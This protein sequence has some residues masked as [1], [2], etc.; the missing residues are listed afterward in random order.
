MGSDVVAAVGEFFRVEKFLKDLNTTSIA[1]IPKK[2]EACSLGDYRP[3]SCCNVVYKVISKIIANRLKPILKK[4]VSPNQAAFL[5][6]RSLGENVLLASELIRDYNKNT[7]L[8]SDMLK[9]DIRKAF[10]TVCWDFI[11][12][13]LQAQ[14]FP[15]M[16]TTW[17]RECIS[18]PRFSVAINGEL[19]GFFQ[20]KKGL[21]QGDSISP[22]LFIMVMEVLS[23]LLD[24][25]ELHNSFR[26]H[27]L[28]STP[29]LTHLLF[30]DDLLVFSDG[31]RSSTNGI[32]SVMATF[33]SW[34]GLDMNNA[35]SE[36]FFGGYPDIQASVMADLLGFRRG[37][38]PTRYLGLLLD[39]KK[40]N[41]ATLQPFLER[42]TSKLHSWTVK[43]LSFA[44]KVKLIYSVIYGM[45][46]FWSSVFVLPKRFY[47]KVDSLCASFLWKNSTS[48]S[49]GA[50]VSWTDICR[51]K[52][53]GGLGLRQLEDYDLVFRLKRLWNFFSNSGSLWVAWLSHNRFRDQNYWLV[54][55]S[56]RFSP[57][58]RGMLQ[59]KNLIPQFL[60][61]IVGDGQYASFWYDYWTELGP[62][63][64]MFGSSGTRQLQIPISASVSEAVVNG[65]WFIPSARSE[66]A[67]T[68]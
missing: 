38:F 1:L 17:V 59:L 25:A 23:R 46:N 37:T 14:G 61:C 62:L 49:V 67:V 51:P 5:K 29:R 22:Y 68:L 32:K 45:L 65:N 8:K 54:R 15:Q 30:A 9:V 57:T 10:D 43:C 60:R 48:S 27:P 6:G 64:I 18:S 7:C 19:A 58:I 53:E 26:M 13:L 4:C 31:S 50:R 42:I 11:I 44:G 33:K 24:R 41:M 55:D 21:R 20:G 66:E 34:S 12:K 56:Q 35:K 28:C 16:F 36:I 52:T 2:P 3:I 39:P 40:I 63:S 47:A